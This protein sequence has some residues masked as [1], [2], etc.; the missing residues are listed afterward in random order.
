MALMLTRIQVDDFDA[1]KEIFDADPFGVRA[2]AKGH[3]LVRGVEDP[4]Q[5][6]IQ[7]EFGSAEDANAA[8]GRLLDAGVLDRVQ[9]VTGPTVGEMAESIQY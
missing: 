9:V 3:R 6:F 1:W 7:V 5:V 8:R 4:N 2:D